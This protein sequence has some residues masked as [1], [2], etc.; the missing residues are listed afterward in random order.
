MADLIRENDQEAFAY[1]DIGVLLGRAIRRSA[2]CQGDYVLGEETIR[3]TVIGAGCHST[4]LSGSTVF[5]RDVAFPL[6]NLPVLALTDQE[7]AL[8]A[9]PLAER[10]RQLRARWEEDTPAALFCPVCKIRAM[11]TCGICPAAWRKYCPSWAAPG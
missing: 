3:A 10:I 7:Q 11:T 8:P 5:A 6:Q 9:R 2:L 4:Q 1:G